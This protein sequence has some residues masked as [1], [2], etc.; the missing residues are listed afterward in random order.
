MVKYLNVSVFFIFLALSSC[1]RK[2]TAP[3]SL[4]VLEIIGKARITLPTHE[5]RDAQPG[6]AVPAG[7]QIAVAFGSRL[8]VGV[9]EYRMLCAGENTVFSID[10]IVDSGP[11]TAVAVRISEGKILCSIDARIGAD[12]LSIGMLDR[13]V[14][15]VI[16][17]TKGGER[18]VLKT[19]GGSLSAALPDSQNTVI[20]SCC[21]MLFGECRR[22]SEPMPLTT[23]DFE[24]LVWF[25]GKNAADSLIDNALCPQ[26]VKNEQNFPPQWETA[27]EAEGVAGKEL[28]DTLF[29]IDPEGSPVTYRLVDGPKGM[30]VDTQSGLVRFVSKSPAT[31]SIEVAA[32]DSFNASSHMTYKLII[33]APLQ[34]SSKQ[35]PRAAINLPGGAPTGEMVR[36]DASRSA[37]SEALLKKYSFRFDVNGDGVW[38]YPAGGAFGEHPSV[39]HA[40]KN[41]G[42]YTVTVQVKNA[43]G[44]TAEAR[45]TIA[46]HAKPQARISLSQQKVKVDQECVFDAGGSS[47]SVSGLPYVVRWDMDNNGT[48]DFPDNGGYCSATTFKKSWNQP[49]RYTVVLEIKD[50]FGALAWASAEVQVLP[51][52]APAQPQTAA[53][54]KPAIVKAGGPYRTRAGRA[55]SLEGEAQ[56]PDSK[57]ERFSWDFQADGSYDT[58]FPAPAKVQHTYGKPGVYRAVFKVVTDDRKEWFDTAAVMVEN[59]PPV[60]HAGEDIVSEKG[61]QVSLRGSGE[62]AE[63]SVALYEWDFNADGAIDWSSPKSGKV[64]HAFDRSASA[65]LRVTD[66]QG[67][68]A[69]DTLRVVICTEGMTAV[70]EGPSGPFCIDDFEWP[71]SRGK[72]PL[73]EVTFIQAREKCAAEG[74][75]LCT[76]KE[77]ELACAGSH[78]VRYP[79]SRSPDE[80]NCNVA[81]NHAFV[82]RVAPS[83]SLSDCRSPAGIFD[84]NG[85]VCEWVEEGGPDSA[86]V[87]GGS[88]HHELGNARCG[89]K[90]SLAKNRGYFYVGFRCCK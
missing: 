33:Q 55:L 57:I 12:A 9:N 25:M 70:E 31:H 52:P 89:S 51:P 86:F 60:A 32:F 71:N 82:N 90:M 73:R 11:R 72:E 13:D 27:P 79:K 36:I 46:I 2:N 74:K 23:K 5:C 85:N 24:E 7:S 16:R 44:K 41:E 15:A 20:P 68:A 50:G 37:R 80:Q 87:Y 1:Q 10:S 30:T 14:T 77:W 17:I 84:M 42:N 34:K 38:E 69:T 49:G 78:G 22:A 81:G 39:T 47:V 88:W 65:V 63:G 64:K 8:S 45:G 3:A 59:T 19:I 53:E 62:D 28:L 75:R 58:S 43:D 56:D 21:K 26:S 76:G 61:K 67:T 18:I 48:W 29:A 40:F 83:G 54:G 66:E 6:M 4:P 35:T